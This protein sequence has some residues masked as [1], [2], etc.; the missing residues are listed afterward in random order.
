[1]RVRNVVV[2]VMLLACA[3]P[4]SRQQPPIP[5][6]LAWPRS[7]SGYGVDYL[8]SISKPEDLAIRRGF[9][10]RLVDIAFGPS[11]APRKLLRPFAVVSD[12]R[13]RLVVV[14][15]S[16]NAVHILDPARRW[17]KAL[18]GPARELFQSPVGVDTDSAGNIYV[19]DSTLGKIFV[20]DRDGKFR[21]FLGDA[22]GEGLFKRPT[23]LAVDKKTGEIYLTD[24][25][26][27]KVYVLDARGAVKREW[28][29]RGEESGEFNFP[30]A[31]ALH[32][33]RVVVLDTMNF[34]VQIFDRSGT[35]LS[36]FGKP[37][38]EP[39]G[40]FRP[41]GLAIDAERKLI[42]V[43]DAMFEVVQAFTFDGKLV[44]AFGEPGSEP[45]RFR[46][47]SG[48]CSTADG[49]LLVADAYNGRIQVF[50]AF[51]L[52]GGGRQ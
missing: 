7:G 23:G 42:L 22:R 32:E 13:G 8:E 47:A 49:R 21:R 44:F 31:V 4:A 45:G 17:H 16:V 3:M 30:T 5:V 29:K 12:V 34:R 6:R 39:G 25:L 40:F 15:N 14:D 48:L 28:G 46:L 19:S 27:H 35:Y 50:R 52:P 33:E 18:Q 11:E 51:A 43:G 20:F 36:S 24:T 26:R 37:A 38:N 1:M 41:K 2:L 10:T 9:L